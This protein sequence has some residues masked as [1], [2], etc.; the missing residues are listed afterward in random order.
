MNLREIEWE[1]EVVILELKIKLYKQI[2]EQS[3]QPNGKHRGKSETKEEWMYQW[4]RIPVR[5]EI[6]KCGWKII[7]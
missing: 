2:N 4:I 6:K 5:K 7:E 3:Y 1:K